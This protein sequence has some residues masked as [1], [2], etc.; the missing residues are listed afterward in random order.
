MIELIFGI[1]TILLL[2]YCAACMLGA[3]KYRAGLARVSEKDFPLKKLM[4]IGLTTQKLLMKASHSSRMFIGGREVRR[5][6]SIVY[7]ENQLKFYTMVYSADALTY[8]A[9]ILTIGCLLTAGTGMPELIALTAL[10]G[11]VVV[12]L[13]LPKRLDEYIANRQ[14]AIRLEF[15][16]FLSKFILLL[17]AGMA[18][19]EAWD[20]AGR[21]EDMNTPFYREVAQ[22]NHEINALGKAPAEALRAFAIRMRDPDVSHFV[23]SVVQYIEYGGGDLSEVLST[24]SAEAWRNRKQEALRLGEVAGTKL[25]G[26]MLLMFLGILILVLAPAIFTMSQ[27]F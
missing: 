6:L 17:G 11:A 13:L 7:G 4:P 21:V 15:P 20:T 9:V 5:K 16:D 14:Q 19:T 8:I 1:L 10:M 27:G 3:K 18:V 12:A 26:T 23:S 24:Q 25:M 2:V 22:T